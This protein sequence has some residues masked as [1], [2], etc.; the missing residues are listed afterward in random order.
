M[1]TGRERVNST[2]YFVMSVP[3]T[4]LNVSYYLPAAAQPIHNW[5]NISSKKELR[6]PGPKTAPQRRPPRL[7]RRL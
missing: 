2:H 7:Q 1:S 5:P 4:L 3:G 6:P